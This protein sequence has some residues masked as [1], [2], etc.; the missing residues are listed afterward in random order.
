M[1]EERLNDLLAVK[2]LSA[3]IQTF[4]PL[5]GIE[6]WNTSSVRTR[7]P[8]LKDRASKRESSTAVVN[9]AA[10]NTTVSAASSV[11]IPIASPVVGIAAE[12]DFNAASVV[13][14]PETATSAPVAHSTEVNPQS[15]SEEALP[16]AVVLP[17]DE[18]PEEALDAEII[19]CTDDDEERDSGVDDSDFEEEFVDRL[20]Q[21][22]L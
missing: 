17:V 8:L 14:D 19:G 1:S 18:E 5:P 21:K 22:Y 3:D 9:V 20:I 2:L 13:L 6:L 11:A 4:D 16:S 12:S 15:N 7:R 10:D